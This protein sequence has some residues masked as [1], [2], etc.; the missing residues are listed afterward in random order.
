MSFDL[1]IYIKDPSRFSVADCEAYLDTLGFHGHFDPDFHPQAFEGCLP[2]VGTSDLVGDGVI[3]RIAPEYY[4]DEY[5]F[6][7]APPRKPT[8]WERLTGKRPAEAIPEEDPFSGATHSILLSCSYGD[9]LSILLAYGIA[10]YAV[11][12]CDGVL[13]DPQDDKAYHTPADVEKAFAVCL[14]DLRDEK[15]KGRLCLHR[16][17]DETL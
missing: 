8:L 3:Y 5:T 15:E 17:G 9:S 13:Y 14:E 1:H 2:F 6:E 7:P 11:G 10:A 4:L 12:G 16:D